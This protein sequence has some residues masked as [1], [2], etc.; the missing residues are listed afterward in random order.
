MTLFGLH[1]YWLVGLGVG[2]AWMLL[3]A[4]YGG[5]RSGPAPGLSYVT[6]PMGA[7]KSYFLVREIEEALG[8][9][10]YVITNVKLKPDAFRRIAR[11]EFVAPLLTGG[12]KRRARRLAS[13]YVYV[14]DI[15]EAVAHRLPCRCPGVPRGGVC[16][17]EVHVPPREG[18]GL[19][20]WDEGQ[21]QLW[22]RDWN[23]PELKQQ[24]KRLLKIMTRLRKMGYACL[25]ASQ[26]KDNTE[27]QL[28]NI[29]TWEIRLVNQREM[30]RILG[31]RIL[32]MPLF[33]AGYYAAQ[34][35]M[36]NARPEYTKRYLLNWKRK[37]YSTVDLTYGQFTDADPDGLPPVLLPRL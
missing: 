29:C 2:V 15:E 7:G 32:P 19:I 35:A 33:L 24:R 3:N 20:A 10:R 22:N 21:D 34:N 9:G 13:R 25:L 17:N 23:D 4:R 37:L 11:H 30:G 28:R 31:V 12:F 36:P 5:H 26:N 18:D 16:G 8:K 27:K 6:G 14:T 1:G